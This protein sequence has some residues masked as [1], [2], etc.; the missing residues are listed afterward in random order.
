MDSRELGS[1]LVPCA[2][3]GSPRV[4]CSPVL[5]AVLLAN[6]AQTILSFSDFRVRD[7]IL[8]FDVAVALADTLEFFGTDQI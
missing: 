7:R 3:F 8:G 5:A 2:S 1:P 6:A 4:P